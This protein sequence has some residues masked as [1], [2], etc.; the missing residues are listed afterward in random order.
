MEDMILIE[1]YSSP[2][3]F[4]LHIHIEDRLAVQIA[5]KTIFLL[6]G[7]VSLDILIL[8]TM[9]ILKSVLF[10]WS[11]IPLRFFYCCF[12]YIF[13]SNVL[14]Y[15]LPITLELAE[16][17]LKS[18]TNL[19]KAFSKVSGTLPVVFIKSLKNGHRLF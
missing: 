14:I 10:V 16:S 12:N 2:R 4:E 9:S 18:L 19:A 1:E 11:L 13:V 5:N 15:I 3:L 6:K 8:F 17:S 7:T